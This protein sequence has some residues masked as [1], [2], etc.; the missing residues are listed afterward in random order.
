MK[1][2]ILHVRARPRLYVALAAGAAVAAL[3]PPAQRWTTRA[4]IGWNVAIWLYVLGMGLMMHRVDHARLRDVASRHAEGAVSVM[5]GV[6]CAVTA[7]LAAIIGELAD[8]HAPGQRQAWH[9]VAL[10]LTTL[11]GSWL[12]LPMLFAI[13]YASVFFR[14]GRAGAG[15]EFPGNE[16]SPDYLDFFYFAVTLAATSQTSDVSV[17]TRPMRRWVL[18]Q[19]LISFAFNTTLLAL[20]INIA[21]GLL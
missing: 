11:V 13:S 14:S 19:T 1:R 18:A 5:V 2:L 15:L 12:L 17:T 16:T 10:A 21:A 7:S 3:L 6:V 4:L 8:L 20:A 9:H